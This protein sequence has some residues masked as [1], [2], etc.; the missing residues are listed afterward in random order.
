MVTAALTL[1]LLDTCVGLRAT[2]VWVLAVAA[3]P[4]ACEG[5]DCPLATDLPTGCQQVS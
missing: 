4:Q 2:I 5:G 1:Y 3:R